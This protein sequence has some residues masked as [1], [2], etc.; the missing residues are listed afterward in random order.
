MEWSLQELKTGAAEIKQMIVAKTAVMHL[1]NTTTW[2]EAEERYPTFACE[3]HK[4]V[5][6]DLSKAILEVLTSAHGQSFQKESQTALLMRVFLSN[7][8]VS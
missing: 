4:F 6:L 1:T 5:R 2:E 3:N 7:M 8:A